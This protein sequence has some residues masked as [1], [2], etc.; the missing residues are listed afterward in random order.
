MRSVR[1]AERKDPL[2]EPRLNEGHLGRTGLTAGCQ[3]AGRRCL[4]SPPPKAELPH[5]T[6]T[7]GF[8]CLIYALGVRFRLN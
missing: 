8:L 5:P 4:W 2:E 6:P 1:S 7:R 3:I